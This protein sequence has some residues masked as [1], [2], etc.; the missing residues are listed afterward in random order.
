MKYTD[1]QIEDLIAGIYAGTI[2]EYDLPRDLYFATAEYLE[3]AIYKGF[4]NTVIELTGK[5]Y[6]LLVELRENIYIFSAAKTF[7][8]VRE[9]TDLLYNDEGVKGFSAFKKDALQ[10]YEQYNV[11]WLRTEYD[12]AIGQAQSAERWQQIEEQADVLPM[13]KYSA[14][15]DKNTSDICRPLDGIVLPVN[16]KFWN[17]HAPLN[18]FNCFE[19]GTQIFTPNGWIEINTLKVGDLVIGGD[20]NAHNI[21][22]VHINSFV[23]ELVNITVKNKTVSSTENHRYLTLTG[24]KCA[25][26]ISVDDVIIQ[27]IEVGFF[28]KAICA[29]NNF[30]TL[31]LYVA[32]PIKRKWKS[33]THTFYTYFKFGQININKSFAD[34]FITYTRHT[35]IREKIKN[36]LLTI[37]KFFM[38]L[39]HSLR[40]FVVSFNSFVISSLSNIQIKHRVTNFHSFA[41]IGARDTQ[42]RMW[43]QFAGFGKFL[44]SIQSSFSSVYPLSFNGFTSFSGSKI[45]IPK[46]SHKRSVIDIP[47]FAN[48]TERFK[49]GEVDSVEGFVSGAPLDSF[50]SLFSFVAHSFFHRKFFLV[51]NVSKKYY[52]GQI[53]NLS[54]NTANSYITNVGVVHNCRCLLLQVD[55][56]ATPP[57]IVKKAKEEVDKDMQPMFKMNPGK[58][59]VIFSDKHP[60]FDVAP[61]DKAFARRNYDL[62]IPEIKKN[63]KFATN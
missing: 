21:D 3:K 48:K 10:L 33:L 59:K 24:W 18:H 11:N 15:I 28:N 6:E 25:K 36:L 44:R 8:Q 56:K 5:P 55:G 41:G 23:G 60:Y 37:G 13:L 45:K 54:V 9:L 27:N 63:S 46:K 61:K 17:T 4:G 35:F 14:V 62:P 16:D 31:L 34:K 52:K 26:N 32:M 58:D 2:T 29:I 19:F 7:T 1:E 22:V 57:S 12:T 39:P 53:Y 30:Y 38:I 50:N 42:T 20:G 43:M 40:L 47:F 49:L 51:K